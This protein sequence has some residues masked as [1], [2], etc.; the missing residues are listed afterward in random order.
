MEQGIAEFKI[1]KK[2]KLKSRFKNVPFL[3]ETGN[4]NPVHLLG[5]EK[6]L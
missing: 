4:Q 6:G 1:S 3:K 5:A 2:A